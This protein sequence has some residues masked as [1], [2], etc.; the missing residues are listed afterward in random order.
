MCQR[1]DLPTRRVIAAPE[2][3]LTQIQDQTNHNIQLSDSK[4]E[5]IFKGMLLFKQNK[6]LSWLFPQYF[7]LNIFGTDIGIHI[8]IKI[9]VNVSHLLS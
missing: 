5:Q 7:K 3:F 6:H 4:I 1:S 9:E 8:C 2:L